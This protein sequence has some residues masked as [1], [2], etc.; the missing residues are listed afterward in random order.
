MMDRSQ[1]VMQALQ[2]MQA[3]QQQAPQ[4]PDLAGMAAQAQQRQ[5]WE[6]ANPGQSYMKQGLASAMA[7]VKGA[8]AAMMAAPQNLKGLF[9]LGQ[10]MR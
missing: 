7:G 4:G 3:P 1:Y 9:S 2:A 10:G 8:P 5:A 6:K